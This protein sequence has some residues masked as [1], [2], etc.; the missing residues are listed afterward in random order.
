MQDNFDLMETNEISNSRAQGGTEM[1]MRFLYNGNIPREL[2][3]NVQIIPSRLRG[4]KEDKIR[5]WFEHNLPEDPESMKPFVDAAV[6]EKFHKYVF[7]S[8]WHYQAFLSHLKIPYSTKCCVLEGGMHCIE[9]FDKDPLLPTKPDPNE[10]VHISYHTTPH[11]GLELIVPVFL[12]LAE[13]DKNI[14]LHVHSSFKMYGWD[15][16]DLR[17]QKVFDICKNHPQITYHGFTKHEDLM[18]QLRDKYHIFAYP[19]IWPETMCRALLEAMYYGLVCVHPDLAALPDTSG[20]LNR[21]M[22]NGT[23]NHNEHA[24]IHYAY[25]KQAIH[26]VRMNTPEHVK[27]LQFNREYIQ[28]RYNTETVYDKW[29]AMLAELNDAYP[30]VESRAFPQEMFVYKV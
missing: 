27:S 24:N 16:E 7:L 4:L 30:T 20:A 26:E 10:C 22:Y 5:V 11:R 19:N 6:K 23:N 3:E 9:P 17:F 15:N 18:V 29:I 8:N 13:E 28:R 21:F 1:Y 2:L 25:L 12:K 14:H